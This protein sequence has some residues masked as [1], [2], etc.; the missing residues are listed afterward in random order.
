MQAEVVGAQAVKSKG[1]E[2]AVD[3]TRSLGQSRQMLSFQDS[4]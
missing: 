2:L 3:G 1:L 4:Y